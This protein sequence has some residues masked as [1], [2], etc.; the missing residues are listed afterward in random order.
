LRNAKR[1]NPN[2]AQ[3]AAAKVCLLLFAAIDHDVSDFGVAFEDKNED[4][5]EKEE[6]EDDDDDD[7]GGNGEEEGEE[8]GRGGE[9]R[10]LKTK[11]AA[12]YVMCA[13]TIAP[14]TTTRLLLRISRVCSIYS[15]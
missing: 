14:I 9:T 10:C 8:E 12:T 1:A 7:D 3:A 13:T 15:W 2:K 5:E 6:E 11:D 4:E